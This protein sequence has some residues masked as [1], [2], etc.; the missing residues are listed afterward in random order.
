MISMWVEIGVDD[1]CLV[2]VPLLQRH[3]PVDRKSTDARSDR[4]GHLLSERQHERLRQQR[5]PGELAAPGRG[6]LHHSAIMPLHPRDA[7][8]EVT[9]V[10]EAVQVSLGLAHPVVHRMIS[11]R[12]AQAPQRRLPTSKSS[13]RSS[14]LW[15]GAKFIPAMSRGLLMPIRGSS[16]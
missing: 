16:R 7:R 2:H 6:D 10:L 9:L 4:K 5:E 15:L 8:L 12:A 11:H 3:R 1:H 13:W 14:C